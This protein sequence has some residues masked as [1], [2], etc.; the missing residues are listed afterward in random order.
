MSSWKT[1]SRRVILEHSMYLTVE[2]HTVELPDGRVIEHWPWI[3]TPDFVNVLPYSAGGEFLCF[4]QEK[5]ALEGLS[6]A[7]V[8]GYIEP[9]E[10]PLAAAQ[11]E[12]REEMGCIA[13]EW[14]HLGS[15]KAGANRGIATGHLY[16]ALDARQSGEPCSDDLEPQELVRLS[17][18]EMEDAVMAGEFKLVPW[19]ANV[20]LALLA[21]RR[22]GIRWD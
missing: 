13:D 19:S 15:Y 3:I 14:V 17:P 7:P 16:L 2:E 12:L 21:L 10:A 20:A 11:R 9:G 8:G 5:Y 18:R 22:R 6:L 4:R 1:L